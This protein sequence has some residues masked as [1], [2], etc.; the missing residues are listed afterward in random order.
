MVGERM[1][2]EATVEG[3]A[4]ITLSKLGVVVEMKIWAPDPPEEDD[5]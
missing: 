4:T 5:E 1:T 3:D 2:F